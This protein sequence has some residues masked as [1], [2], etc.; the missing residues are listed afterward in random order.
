MPGLETALVRGLA[1]D[2]EGAYRHR[3]ALERRGAQVAEGEQAAQ[4]SARALGDNHCP[5]FGQPLQSGGETGGL[6]DDR[7][8]LRGLLA[9][10]LAYDDEPGGDANT[11]G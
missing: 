3:E 11:A 8:L 9:D 10:P 6:T 5:R 4:E 1:G 2:G 7:L